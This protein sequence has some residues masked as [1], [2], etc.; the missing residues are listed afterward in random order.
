MPKYRTALHGIDHA[1]TLSIIYPAVLKVCKKAKHKKL[2]QYGKRV[3]KSTNTDEELLI[4]EA[5][6][7]T[8]EFFQTMQLPTSLSDVELGKSDIDPILK[9]LEQHRM[10]KLGE[11]MDVDLEVSRKI[12]E[13]AV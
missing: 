5:I 12:L 4:D 8:I 10:V 11:H 3:W 1:R 7:K 6:N 2:V 9:K 13:M